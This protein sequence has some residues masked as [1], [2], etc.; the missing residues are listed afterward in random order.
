MEIVV[1]APDFGPGSVVDAP[2]LGPGSVGFARRRSPAI[3]CGGFI[4]MGKE[5]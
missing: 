2:D 1:D 5:G 4:A 3:H